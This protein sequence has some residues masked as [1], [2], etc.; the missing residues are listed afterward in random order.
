MTQNNAPLQVYDVDAMEYIVIGQEHAGRTE[1]ELAKAYVGEGMQVTKLTLYC[2][3]MKNGHTYPNY[4]TLK[5][6]YVF[7]ESVTLFLQYALKG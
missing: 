2:M 3:R 5:H 1:I 7:L 4:L 6:S